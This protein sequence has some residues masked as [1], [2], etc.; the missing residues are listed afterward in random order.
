MFK[1]G[2][3]K[4]AAGRKLAT[5]VALSTALCSAQAQNGKE[6]ANNA[7]IA[8]G[9][10]KVVSLAVGASDLNPVTSI[11]SIGVSAAVF[12]YAD[13]LPETERPRAYAAAT[14]LWQGAAANNLC[15]TAAFLTGGS[16]TPACVALGLAWAMKTWDDTEHERRF[17][18]RCAIL[19]EFSDQP[20]FPC[21]YTPPEKDEVVE[22]KSA[23][24]GGID[25]EAP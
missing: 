7:A 19:R 22:A 16:F 13:G 15:L 1:S 24:A 25:S 5:A 2:P 12:Q 4:F 9:F 10:T 14:S 20:E 18:E 6:Q 8:D 21:V 17:W 3:G 11:L 23:Q